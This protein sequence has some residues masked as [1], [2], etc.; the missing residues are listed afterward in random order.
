MSTKSLHIAA[1]LKNL[2]AIR[3]FIEKTARALG[4]DPAI[5]PDLL[6]AVD[7]AA[8]NIIVHGYQGQEGPIEVEVEREGDALVIR[9][10]DEA[11]PFDPT[12][13]PPPDLSLPLEQRSPG[14]V[15]IYLMRQ[16]VEQVTHRCTPQGGNELTLVKKG[17][18]K[19]Q[20]K[21][22]IGPVTVLSV[23]GYVDAAT[24]PQLISEAA[25]VL[26]KGHVNLVL[27]LGGVDYISSGGLIALQTIAGRAASRGGKAVLCCV[28]EQVAKVLK[29]SGFDQR[30]S[31]FPDVAAAMASFA[32]T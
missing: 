14:G 5:V 25:Q 23:T 6:L 10:R 1:E 16:C 11:A 17:V 8:T 32:G 21:T 22:T 12:A 2:A 4:V 20:V 13:I 24:F 30:L 26:D 7:E 19:M 31:I 29:I 3:R 9:L 18:G 15:G 27:D 28:R